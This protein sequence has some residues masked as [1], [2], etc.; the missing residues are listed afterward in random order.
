MKDKTCG[1]VIDW[2]VEW[3]PKMYR[4]LVDYTTEHIK[5][6]G[7]IKR[8]VEKITHSEYKD[9]L[10]NNKCVIDSMYRSQSKYHKIGTYEIK[11]IS[12]YHFDDKI[13][14]QNNGYEELAIGY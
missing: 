3:K 5:S 2:Q 14:I 12:L 9:V 10:L 4:Y 8:V 1:F 6:K 13:Y 11:K 7:V